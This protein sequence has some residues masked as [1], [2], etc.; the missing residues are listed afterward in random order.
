MTPDVFRNA[1][2]E[3]RLAIAEAR[4][5]QLANVVAD[6]AMALANLSNFVRYQADVEAHIPSLPDIARQ[7][8]MGK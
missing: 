3:R 7:F 1:R 8:G 4:I 2:Y 6:N 5:I